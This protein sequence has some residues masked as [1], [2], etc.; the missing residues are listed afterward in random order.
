LF[1]INKIHPE[2]DICRKPDNCSG[3]SVNF[4]A[5]ILSL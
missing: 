5:I 4:G 2:P 3:F 1:E